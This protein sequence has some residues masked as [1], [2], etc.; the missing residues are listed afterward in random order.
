ME[1]SLANYVEKRKKATT[2]KKKGGYLIL[3]I[4]AFL[5][6]MFFMF[7]YGLGLFGN[8][9]S[10]KVTNANEELEQ[11]R[12]AVI[13]YKTYNLYGSYPASLGEL[14]ESPC[15]TKDESRDG[16]Q[17]DRFLQPNSRWTTS[18]LKDMW[19]NDYVLDTQNGTVYSTA[20]SSDSSD[21]I[22][23]SLGSSSGS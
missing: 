11:I 23:V 22:T 4:T 8:T 7:N 1:F 19:G 21:Y 15:L 14:V 18:S 6:F 3:E 10:A 13:S 17:H 16:R 9:D 5:I 20:G 12:T 2:S